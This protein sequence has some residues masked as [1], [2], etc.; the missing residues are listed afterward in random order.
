MIEQ[1][2]AIP[3]KDGHTATFIVHPE[4]AGPFPVILFYNL[5]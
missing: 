2:I 5:V 1:Q 4:R 3:T